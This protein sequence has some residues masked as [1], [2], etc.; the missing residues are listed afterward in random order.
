MPNF[1]A[2]V[3]AACSFALLA[4]AAS[5]ASNNN[6]TY[7][8]LGDSVAFGFDPTLFA[9]GNPIPKPS[10]FVGYPEVVA[11]V[12][13]PKNGV[14]AACPGESSGSFL[15]VTALDLGCHGLGPQG[16]PPFK[17]SI[18]L[19]ADYNGSQFD[20]AVSEL[21]SNKHINLV[22][23]GIG[24]NDVLIVLGV[25]NNDLNCVNGKLPAVLQTYGENLA[26]ILTGIRSDANY[27][28]GLILVKYYAPSPDLVPIAQALNGVMTQVGRQFGVKF[29]D[30]FTAFQIASALFNHDPCKAG[31]LIRL[32]P[33]T[34]DIHPSPLGRNLLAATVEVARIGL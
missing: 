28:G 9:P 30:G 8:A 29:A 15:D 16:Q 11:Q 22:T 27:K 4:S 32:G 20:F 6:Y 34:C 17:T 26:K 2:G 12:Q 25:C 5:A 31:L 23:L 21:K 24:S 10:D 3:L 18:G 13:Y 7:L 14:N 33:A 19:K 1:K